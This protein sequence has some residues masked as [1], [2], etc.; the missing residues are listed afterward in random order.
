MRLVA[1]SDS[2]GQFDPLYQIVCMQKAHTDLFLH[3]GDG[4]REVEDLQFAFPGLPILAVR[5]NCDYGS[6]LPL[7][8]TLSLNPVSY[9]HL[10]VYKRQSSIMTFSSSSVMVGSSSSS[11]LLTRVKSIKK[12]TIGVRIFIYQ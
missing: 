10:D 4:A 12:A 7:S 8:R 6:T 5:G 3:L 11:F 1:F 9:T 2:H